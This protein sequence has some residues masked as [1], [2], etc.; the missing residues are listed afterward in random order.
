MTSEKK[1][2]YQEI[3]DKVLAAIEAGTA[4]W[5]KPWKG[6]SPWAISHETGKT[7]SIL[8]QILLGKPGEYITWGQVQ[9]AGGKVKKGSKARMIVYWNFQVKEKTDKD[10]NPVLDADGNVIVRQ[11][12]FLQRYNVFHLDDVE[13]I[14][15]KYDKVVEHDHKPDEAAEK[16]LHEYL[17]REGITLEVDKVGRAFYSPQLDKI[18][19]PELTIFDSVPEYYGTAFHEATHS[20]GHKKRLD[21][22]TDCAAFGDENYSK[23]ELVAEL[24]SCFICSKLGLSTESSFRNSAAYLQGWLQALKNDKRLIVTAAGAA[25][26]AAK[27]ILGEG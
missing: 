7:Y 27:M 24:G 5:V 13:G 20:T 3:T 17:T 26:K 6:T 19:L 11:I 12:P 25:E 4:P 15:P 18:H 21:R 16:L 1:D 14:A 9:K 8:N 22:L 23:E 2:I 10:G